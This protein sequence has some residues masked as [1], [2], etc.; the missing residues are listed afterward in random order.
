MWQAA[1]P[2]AW[3][4]RKRGDPPTFPS[5]GYEGLCPDCVLSPTSGDCVGRG[6]KPQRTPPRTPPPSGSLSR[7]NWRQKKKRKKKKEA[8]STKPSVGEERPVGTPVTETVRT[9]LH[10]P[11]RKQIINPSP[12]VDFLFLRI[13]KPPV[14]SVI[15]PL[16]G[17]WV[18]VNLWPQPWLREGFIFCNIHNCGWEQ[19][20]GRYLSMQRKQAHL[21]SV[22]AGSSILL[23]SQALG[24]GLR[25]GYLCVRWIKCKAH[26]RSW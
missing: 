26:F 22:G 12:L 1:A 2:C 5:S 13:P 17:A 8:N 23:S 21:S 9:T 6:R 14:V 16:N 11:Q 24:L 20:D 19:R 10:P 7:R 25:P 4:R 18:W 15:C 3:V